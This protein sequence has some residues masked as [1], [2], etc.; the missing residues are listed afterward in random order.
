MIEE[1]SRK[2]ESR[3]GKPAD[4]RNIHR[5]R[6][7]P[8][9]HNELVRFSRWRNPMNHPAVMFRRSAVLAAGNYR[10]M[11]DFEDYDLWLRMI[12]GGAQL[13]NL[14]ETLVYMRIAGG[15]YQRRGGLGYV[16]SNLR[17]WRT[18]YAEGLV[19]LPEFL[20]MVIC[21]TVVSLLPGFFRRGFYRI[22]L[23]ET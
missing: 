14:E 8:L 9:S 12:R 19:N 7:L 16:R 5:I 1:F 20:V 13:G 23:R 15:L 21:H 17:F 6:R 11:P 22:W 2:A 4:T 10:D 18:A 3:H